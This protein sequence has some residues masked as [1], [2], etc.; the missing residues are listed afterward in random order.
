MGFKPPRWERKEMDVLLLSIGL[1]ITIAGAVIV[2]ALF[3]L[4]RTGT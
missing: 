2:L 1:I 3:G 4:M